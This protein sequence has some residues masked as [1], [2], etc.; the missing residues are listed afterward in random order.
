MTG[1]ASVARA[2][3]VATAPSERWRRTGRSPQHII[4]PRTSRPVDAAWR[5]VRVADD[6]AITATAAATAA[7]VLGSAAPP[8]LRARN[9]TARLV[10]PAG[11]T[12]DVSPI[13]RQQSVV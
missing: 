8:W 13:N 5:S 11:D 10:T 1:V 12:L 9:L 7:M 6:D 3:S 2:A 4:D